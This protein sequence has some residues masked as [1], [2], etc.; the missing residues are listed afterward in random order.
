M[1]F[2]V[3]FFRLLGARRLRIAWGSSSSLLG[4]CGDGERSSLRDCLRLSVP[5]FSVLLS[6]IAVMISPFT[7]LPLHRAVLTLG[8]S[9]FDQSSSSKLSNVSGVQEKCFLALGSTLDVVR[10]CWNRSLKLPADCFCGVSV[11]ESDSFWNGMRPRL[12]VEARIVSW[13]PSV[14][15][16]REPISLVL[17]V[18]P[19]IASS[20]TVACRKSST[21]VQ[22][23]CLSSSAICF[24]PFAGW[25]WRGAQVA[26]LLMGAGLGIDGGLE[27][28]SAD[29]GSSSP[30]ADLVGE[31]KERARVCPPRMTVLLRSLGVAWLCAS[32]M[33][34]LRSSSLVYLTAGVSSYPHCASK[35]DAIAWRGSTVLLAA[36]FL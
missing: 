27:Y 3:V 23:P 9:Q 21:N 6:G 20:P 11:A 17:F 4:V 25:L 26:R 1:K 34:F 10:L 36:R 12:E 32:R 13:S 22:R 15:L 19:E 16:D 18:V 8:D 2:E 28:A 5:S 31:S 29:R 30:F 35:T 14:L 7:V 33:A 24:M